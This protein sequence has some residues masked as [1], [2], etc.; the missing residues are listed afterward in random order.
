MISG[1]GFFLRGPDRSLE[2][3]FINKEEIDSGGKLK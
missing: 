1:L 2:G 3:M